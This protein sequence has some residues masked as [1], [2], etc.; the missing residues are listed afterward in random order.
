MNKAILKQLLKEYRNCHNEKRFHKDMMKKIDTASIPIKKLSDAEIKSINDFWGKYGVKPD[1]ATFQ[2]YYSVNGIIDNR[3]ISEG[4]YT[5]FIW[6]VLNDMSRCK[7]LNDKNLLDVFYPRELL[8]NTIFHNINGVILDDEYRPITYDEAFKIAA[9]E[10]KIVIKPAIDSCQGNGIVCVLGNELPDVLKRYDKDYIVQSVV[11][12]HPSFSILND[13]S[14]NVVR[15][16]SLLIDQ[17]VVILDSIIRIGAPGSFTDHKNIAIGINNDGSL[18]EY[19]YTVTGEKVSKLANGFEFSG[20]KLEGFD[21]MK[22]IA[23]D[24]H[25]K[26]PQARLIGWDLTTN[27]NGDVIIIEA[28]MDF[29]GIGRGQDCNGPFFGEYTEKV[30]DMVFKNEG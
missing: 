26:T 6:T 2:W 24:L 27:Q 3:Y 10:Q 15:M 16:T 23:S 28:N 22:R 12:Q 1:Y 17:E 8:P 21:E 19:G 13:S 14:V 9:K 25:V 5:N 4:V 29:P 11:K 18:K 20:H 7:G 30:L